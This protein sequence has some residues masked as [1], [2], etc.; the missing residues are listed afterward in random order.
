[1]QFRLCTIGGGV[2]GDITDNDGEDIQP[3]KSEG[4]GG[5]SNARVSKRKTTKTAEEIRKASDD[6]VARR[7]V[8]RAAA[9]PE[10]KKECRDADAAR[11][12][13]SRAA[14]T[15]EKKKVLGD[16]DAARKKDSRADATEEKTQERLDADAEGKRASRAALTAEN[17]RERREK[18]AAQDKARQADA[19]EEEAKRA[20]GVTTPQQNARRLRQRKADTEARKSS[21]PERTPVQ[22]ERERRDTAKREVDLRYRESER[23]RMAKLRSNP[24]FKELQQVRE[25]QC[26]NSTALDFSAYN[27]ARVGKLH[28]SNMDPPTADQLLFPERNALASAQLYHHVTGHEF[29]DPIREYSELRYS[30]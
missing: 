21:R 15:P 28:P 6:K 13:I 27:R 29:V 12:E 7:K 9:T 19:T 4:D 22:V 24:I 25:G 23:L 11:K 5:V 17:A 2:D 30:E 26:R 3:K 18:R 14:E 8:S 10:K 1:M 20:R 16:A